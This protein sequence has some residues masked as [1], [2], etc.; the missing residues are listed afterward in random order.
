VCVEGVKEET[1]ES[2]QCNGSA[3]EKGTLICSETVKL[4]DRLALVTN[5]IGQRVLYELQVSGDVCVMLCDQ[6]GIPEEC[7][8]CSK[9]SL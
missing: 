2:C 4:H 3:T 6:G 5:R 8:Y 9:P 7:V 1:Q